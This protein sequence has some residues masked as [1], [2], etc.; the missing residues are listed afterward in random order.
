LEVG[1]LSAYGLGRTGDGFGFGVRFSGTIPSSIS[2]V[3]LRFL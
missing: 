1:K 2:G 3:A